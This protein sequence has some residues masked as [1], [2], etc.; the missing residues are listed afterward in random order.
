M[1]SVE[2][3]MTV[4][5]GT[6]NWSSANGGGKAEKEV[7]LELELEL[8]LDGSRAERSLCSGE[9]GGSCWVSCELG[10]GRRGGYE[11]CG[12]LDVD[13]HVRLKARHGEVVTEGGRRAS[14]RW[15]T[16][17]LRLEFEDFGA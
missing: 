10:G 8:E 12:L 5:E 1:G 16:T 7:F 14:G 2:R 9:K 13:R 3:G 4:L 11:G 15:R 17:R 6:R